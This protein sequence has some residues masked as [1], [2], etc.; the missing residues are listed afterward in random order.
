MSDAVQE[1]NSQE[2]IIC[3]DEI[4]DITLVFQYYERFNQVLNN[5][6]TIVLNADKVEK[7]DGAGLQLIATFIKS[8]ESL[9]VQ[10]TWSGVSEAF[11][12]NASLIGLSSSLGY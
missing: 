6:K 9:N 12:K 1:P 7:V 11:K 4:L 2:D 8:A 3:F 10:V 5:Q